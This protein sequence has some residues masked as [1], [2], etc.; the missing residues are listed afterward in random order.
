MRV[1]VG[2]DLDRDNVLDPGEIMTTTFICNGV[3]APAADGGTPASCMTN[4]DCPFSTNPCLTPVCGSG[5]VCDSASIPPGGGCSNPPGGVCNG[6]G[7][8]VAP[9]CGDGT[10][11]PGEGCDDGNTDPGD[12]C[13]SG[14]LVEPGF[15][16]NNTQAPSVCRSRTFSAAG[17]TFHYFY[18]FTG[19]SVPAPESGGGDLAL[20]PRLNLAD[21]PDLCDPTI[22]DLRGKIIIAQRGNCSFYEKAIHAAQDGA[23]GVIVYDDLAE[24]LVSPDVTPPAGSPQTT[25]PTAF[26]SQLDGAILTNA[27]L[28]GPVTVT[29]QPFVA[30]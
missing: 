13:A 28:L 4:M 12:G 10:V 15:A 5:G 22:F 19:T 6:S 14:C 25:I 7:V 26:I 9:G 29:W 18:G 1:D 24:G 2:L 23:A 11:G 8:C 27:L 16:C 20:A 3:S 30:P 21:V 17:R